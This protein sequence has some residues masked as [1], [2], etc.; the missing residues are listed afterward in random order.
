MAWYVSTADMPGE[1]RP[2]E[3]TGAW[4]GEALAYM[5]Q[6]GGC[7]SCTDSNDSLLEK[8]SLEK[9]SN[10]HNF[11][12]GPHVSELAHCSPKIM[13]VP[14]TT[15]TTSLLRLPCLWLLVLSSLPCMMSSR[16]CLCLVCRNSHKHGSPPLRAV[17]LASS[18][19]CKAGSCEDHHGCAV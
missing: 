8:V 9:A 4:L 3:C 6:R 18:D 5:R 17:Y 19:G 12:E 2:L 10:M 13:H 14:P 15:A 1:G 16:Q 7:W 11:M